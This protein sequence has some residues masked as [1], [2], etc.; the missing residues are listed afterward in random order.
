[1]GLLG[2][3][4]FNTI[5]RRKEIGI[6]KVLG[7]SVGGI[8]TMLSKDFVKLILIALLVAS[9]ISWWAMNQWLQSFAYRIDIPLWIFFF[10]GLTAVV[11]ALVTIS[12]QSVRAALINPVESLRGE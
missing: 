9:P 1:M 3:S 8:M 10:S 4:A 7:A 5:Q 12:F 6:R 2:L 11:I